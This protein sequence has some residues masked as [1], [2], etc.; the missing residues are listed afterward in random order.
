[1]KLQCIPEEVDSEIIY[2][3]LNKG[4]KISNCEC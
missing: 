3:L 2:I 1:M 4:E